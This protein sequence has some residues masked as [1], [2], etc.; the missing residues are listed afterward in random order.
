MSPKQQAESVAN[1]GHPYE[2]SGAFRKD[3]PVKKLAWIA[4][5]LLLTMPVSQAAGQLTTICAL[6][7]VNG[8]IHGSV[9]DYT[10]NHG[11]DRRI[12]S[13]ALCQCRDMYVYLPPGYRPDQPYPL[14]LWL[15]G[16]TQDE[17]SF[18][19]DVVEKLDEAIVAGKLPPL[20]AAA[21][22]GSLYGH[23]CLIT[24]GSFFVNSKAGRFQ[25]YVL[26]DVWSFM[27]L[28]YPIRPEREAHILAGASMGGG[29]AYNIAIKHRDRFGVVIGIFPPLNNRWLDCHCDYMANFDPCCW[30]WRTS[31][32]N[33]REV[34]GRF[35]GVVRIH[36]RQVIG[37]LYGLGPDAVAA[38]SEENPIELIDRLDL[39]EGELEMYVAY[40]GRDQ[41]NL[42]A[43]VESFL[44]RARQRGLCVAVG[45]DP[46]GKHDLA[47]AYRLFP[48]ILSWLA[49]RLAPYSPPLVL[50]KPIRK[51]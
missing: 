7:R 39:H 14:M 1:R 42:D 4:V 22:D 43:Q 5:L 33:G 12:W 19:T 21:P 49:P 9:I 30:G 27:L 50:C 28:H 24:P 10:H 15:H 18:L 45:Y 3:L 11:A 8:R 40:G 29:G 20:I 13:T 48:D 46:Q 32:S 16:F 47:T 35:Y 41:F 51:L 26:D 2:H 17:K 23:S 44:Y 6:D 37:P 31:V 38:I 34:V 36:M 25:D